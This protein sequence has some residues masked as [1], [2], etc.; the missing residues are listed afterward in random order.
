MNIVAIGLNANV[1]P[2][3]RGEAA[4][5]ASALYK[6]VSSVDKVVSSQFRYGKEC[7]SPEGPGPG[8]G[9]SPAIYLPTPRTNLQTPRMKRTT[10]AMARP[11]SRQRPRKPPESKN[12]TTTTARMLKTTRM[13]KV[14]FLAAAT[15]TP[16][17]VPPRPRKRRPRPPPRSPSPRRPLQRLPSLLLPRPQS[18]SRSPGSASRPHPT[19]HLTIGATPKLPPSSTPITTLS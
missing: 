10:T 18:L 15:T 1:S 13:P 5:A 4:A 12:R 16:W 14:S 17:T 2:A 6:A 11:R 19:P 9:A 3:G 8:A 7:R